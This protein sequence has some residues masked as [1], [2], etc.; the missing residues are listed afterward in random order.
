LALLPEPWLF[1]LLSLADRF[2]P[3]RVFFFS[4]LFAAVLNVGLVHDGNQFFSLLILRFGTGFF[5]AG[6]YPVG[7]KI[8]AD[9]YQKKL[10]NSLSFLVGALVVGT[11]FPHFLRASGVEISWKW[12]ILTT[13]FLAALGG[14]L[15]FF[16]VPDGPY[17]R[18]ALKVDLFATTQ[19][20][21]EWN[22]QAAAFGYFGH[23]WELYAFWMFVPIMLSSY[24]EMHE[25]NVPNL[26]IWAFLIIASGGIACVLGGYLSLHF[27]PAKVATAALL[28]SGICCL[29][30]PLFFSLNSWPAF[31]AFLIFWGMVVVADSPLFS[32]LVA[33]SAKAEVKGTALTIVNSIGFALTIVSIQLLTY[34]LEVISIKYLF[35]ILAI[36][37]IVGLSAGLIKRK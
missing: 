30:S 23:M 22:F 11:A 4:S 20:F 28:T 2:S 33:Q 27:R 10:S 16:L 7:M 1:A 19:V 5:L 8:A 37:P 34:L 29:L 18:P 12:I 9:Y 14:L 31:L 3:S 6:I 13:S 24:G 32:T 25:Y 21:R 35:I 36:G 15:L 17:R 26:S